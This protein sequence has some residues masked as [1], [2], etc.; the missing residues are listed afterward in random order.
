MSY[1]L[2]KRSESFTVV[3]GPLA[4]RTYR[5]GVIYEEIPKSEAARFDKVAPAE[6]APEKDKTGRKN[7]EINARKE[8][9]K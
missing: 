8:D 1:T 4:N 5:H 6:P 3:D 2:K 9:A 7:A